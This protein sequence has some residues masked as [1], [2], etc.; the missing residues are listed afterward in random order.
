MWQAVSYKPSIN[1]IKKAK[2]LSSMKKSVNFVG[3]YGI[4]H[5]YDM[6]KCLF[7]PITLLLLLASCSDKICD[8]MQTKSS[9]SFVPIQING[10]IQQMNLTRANE[11]GFVTGDRMGIYIVDYV[12][13]A[14]GNA[15]QP[16]QIST[17][18]RASNAIYTFDGE[19]YRWTAPTTIYW[20]DETTPVDVYGYYPAANYISNPSAY[21]FEV[22]ADQNLQREGEMSNYEASDFLW[23]KT[24]GTAPTTETIIVQYSHRLA[25]VRVHL[26]KGE[27]M[28]DTEWEKL[29]RLVTV[30]NTVRSAIIDLS[31]GTATSTGS[32]DRPIRMLEQTS[33]YRSVVVP[34]TVAAGKAL[35]S[36]TIDGISY[37][38]TLT[39]P[40]KYQAGKLHNFTITVNKNEATGN[41]SISVKDDG[42]TDWVNDEASHQ[43]SAQAYVIVHCDKMGTL[44]ECITRAG[45]DYKTVQN[46]KVTGE[47][48]ESDMAVLNNEMPEL[49]HLN[50]HDVCM[51]H[52]LT[53]DGWLEYYNHDHDIYEDDVFTGLDRN[54]YIRSLVLPSTIKRAGGLS[55]MSLMYSTLEIPEGVNRITGIG[56][57]DYNGVE[58][59]L[60][61]TIDT[62]DAG[63]FVNCGY[64]CE[65]KLSDNITYIGRG[66]FER[67]PNFYG[68]FHIP[69]KLKELNDAFTELGGS[70][71]GEIEI[72]QGLSYV[73]GLSVALTNWVEITIPAGVK[74]LGAGWP[75][76]ISNI[77][78]NDDLE[79][80]DGKEVFRWH[81]LPFQLKLPPA[82]RKLS[83]HAFSC[84]GLESELIIPENCLDI[85]FGCFENNAFTKIT[86][87]SRLESIDRETFQGNHLLTSITI[88]KYV[89]EIGSRAFGDCD[90]LQ[91]VICLNPEPPLIEDNTFEGLYFD[92]VILEVPESSV[93]SYR[94]DD[95]WKKFLNITAYHELAYNIPEIV[96]MD[97]GV[98]RQGIL[99]AEGEWEVSEC[100]SWVTVSPSSGEYK[101]EVT[102][103]VQPN[104]GDTREGRIVF[105]LKGKNYTTYTDIRQVNAS[106]KED[107]TVTLQTASAGGTPIP[108]FIVGEGYNADDIASGKYLEDMTAQMEHLFSIEPYKT[109]R[110]YFTVSTA[111][112]CSP[113]SGM[114]GLLHF[115]GSNQA[116]W[117]Y[118]QSHGT[119]INDHAAM[120][121]LCNTPAYGCHTDLWENG[122]SFS[123]LGKNAD[124]YP[125][126]QRGDVLHHLGGRGFGKLAPEY[127]N[128]FTFMKACT[129]PGCNMTAEYNW[130]RQKGW[131]QNVSI[132]PKMTELP[133]Y[134]FIFHERYA[135]Y[136]D[137]YEGALNH[138]RSTYRS[139]NQSVMGAAHIYYYNTISRY[140]IV[141]RIMEAAGKTFSIEQFEANDKIEIPE[142]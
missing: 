7:F 86:L 94:H 110:N 71:T 24:A 39:S 105:S 76:R 107:A 42:I 9:D 69:Q 139:E 23:G 85:G 20:R 2:S 135:P 97:K 37:S 17:D 90:A 14:D 80:I 131:W 63:A 51:R 92:K 61:S 72:P 122:L 79:E 62:I 128:H 96:C 64:K 98:T 41:Y 57:C 33:D 6:N 103:T 29:P 130:A 66:A 18:N 28:T 117:Q 127:V 8:M 15:Y 132:T 38:H 55:S 58:L 21:Q 60:P 73:S 78:F 84:C 1:G 123:W 120:L 35:I 43:F 100:P 3:N 77:H 47:L 114:N 124:I 125:Y 68:T 108:I 95:K 81:S 118:A 59:I 40:M 31:T 74:K 133:W 115:N 89:N 36:I 4:Q 116:V 56:W 87:P 111:Y 91:T 119:A 65:L 75:G 44:K 46:L 52:I 109:Y 67:T 13:A 126:D 104:T 16:G 106:V 82:L 25:G 138:A 22:S 53:Y 32:Y 142:E 141:R 50:L 12:S 102:I 11:Q 134:Q 70:F 101:E 88:P 136:V 121:V 137:V 129:C 19:N 10:S 49:R 30:D 26:L 48:T 112:A 54:Q 83:P 140:E 5:R 27:G 93:E 45:L 99:R 113:E 34:Q